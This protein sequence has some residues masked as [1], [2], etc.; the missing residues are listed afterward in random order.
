MRSPPGFK[1]V[2]NAL[3]VQIVDQAPS[4]TKPLAQITDQPK[5]V[6]AGVFWVASINQKV[7]EAVNVWPQG[8]V[9][10]RLKISSP[11]IEVFNHKCPFLSSGSPN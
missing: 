8:A 10:Q 7:S 5:S 2:V 3:L 6:F 4:A 11:R 1:K 9:P